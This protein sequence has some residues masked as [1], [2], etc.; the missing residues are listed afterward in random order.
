M[1][2]VLGA[3]FARTR[4][5]RPNGP[6]TLARLGLVVNLLALAY[7]VGAIVNI[8]WPRPS[9]NDPWYVNYA[10]LV[11][12]VAIVLLGGVYM[13]FARPHGRSSAPSGDAHRL[14]TGKPRP[15]SPIEAIG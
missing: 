8:L 3:L 1:I 2:L 10:M 6:F 4:G 5:W 9:P 7:G 12:T 15:G 13:V 14:A 11:T